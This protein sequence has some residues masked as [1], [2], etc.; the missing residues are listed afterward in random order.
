MPTTLRQ[1]PFSLFTDMK[2]KFKKKTA[3]DIQKLPECPLNL[4]HIWI[5]ISLN[6]YL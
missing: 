6:Y 4:N 2:K 5:S 1:H 3:L